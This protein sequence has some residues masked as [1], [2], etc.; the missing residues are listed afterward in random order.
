[1]IDTPHSSEPTILKSPI[2]VQMNL[3]RPDDVDKV[4]TAIGY[5][6]KG[7]CPLDD[8]PPGAVEYQR[9]LFWSSGAIAF[10][11]SYIGF[12]S[13][14]GFRCFVPPGCKRVLQRST[15]FLTGG[16][17]KITRMDSETI[18]KLV[19]VVAF[20]PVLFILLSPGSLVQVLCDTP[21]DLLDS[22]GSTIS[23]SPAAGGAWSN[24]IQSA[25]YLRRI[26]WSDK[27]I[28]ALQVI[29]AFE[30]WLGY[31]SLL[32]VSEAASFL[33]F[34]VNW[35]RVADKSFSLIGM[36]VSAVLIAIWGGMEYAH[37]SELRFWNDAWRGGVNADP[38]QNVLS[39][40]GNNGH[41]FGYLAQGAEWADPDGPE[42]I[43]CIQPFAQFYAR[44]LAGLHVL[45]FAFYLVLATPPF[46]SYWRSRAV[47]SHLV[48][49]SMSAAI[50]CNARAGGTY[51]L[52]D[53]NNTLTSNPLNTV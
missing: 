25:L 24:G 13:L 8:F 34:V 49:T 31:F 42:R 27:Q 7:F 12:L 16:A 6:L 36:A 32:L 48:Q 37:A 51:K 11:C 1:M 52:P 9:F 41:A 47:K 43:V 10:Y 2:N 5:C 39:S 4:A 23:P 40:L 18:S 44:S 17:S 50:D 53:A 29:A 22:F 45:V 33:I 26:N 15:R 30:V 46:G 14:L 20:A 28:V 38:P 3:T 21:K 19:E 35:S